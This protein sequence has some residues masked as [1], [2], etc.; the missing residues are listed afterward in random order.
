MRLKKPSLRAS[1]NLKARDLAAAA[2]CALGAIY[3][4][5]DDLDE[6]ILRVNAR[7][8]APWS[9]RSIA[10]W[11]GRRGGAGADL[12]RMAQAYLSFARVT[13]S[14]GAPCSN[15]AWRMPVRFRPGIDN[16]NRL[17]RRL[18]APLS[19]LLPG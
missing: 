5:F 11:R 7:T 1:T 12:S 10:H 6:L 15:I 16:R 17:F 2:G 8:L 14:A 13:N 4:V 18:E 3:T 9:A 19:Q